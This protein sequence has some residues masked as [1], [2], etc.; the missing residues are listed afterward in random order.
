MSVLF[1][2]CALVFSLHKHTQIET[3]IH[4]YINSNTNACKRT[5]VTTHTRKKRTRIKK[6][7][8]LY[9]S[10]N[11]STHTF[12]T[13][14]LHLIF[15]FAYT[16]IYRYIYIHAFEHQYMYTKIDNHTYNHEQTDR[17]GTLQSFNASDTNFAKAHLKPQEI[18]TLNT[19]LEN[20]STLQTKYSSC[21]V[22]QGY[23]HHR[24]SAST[25]ILHAKRHDKI[26]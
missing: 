18:A 8:I 6:K 10:H 14:Y 1:S 5:Y 23:D 12:S 20:I 17:E 3:C 2:A 11:Y 21:K 24:R 4:T 26:Y 16:Q 13:L 25:L 22:I 19:L 7:N 15:F 9:V